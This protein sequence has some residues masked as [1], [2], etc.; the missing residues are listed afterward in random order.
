[1]QPGQAIANPYILTPLTNGVGFYGRDSVLQFVRN[2]LNSPY[3][4]VIVLFGQRRIG[5]TSLLH[6]LRQ[7]G[8][9]PA[10][11]RPIY[12]DLQGRAEHA[13]DQVLFGLAREICRTLSIELPPRAAFEDETFFQYGFLPE[14]YRVIGHDRLLVLVDEFDVL[15]GEHVP[16]DAAYHVLFSYLQDL[17][18]DEQRH[19]TFIFV[20]GRRL[21]ELPSRIKATFKSAQCKRISALDRASATDLIVEPAKGLV[22]FDKDAIERLHALTSGHPYF[23]QLLCYELVDRCLRRGN[24]RIGAHD[25]S[26]DVLE[27]AM[28]LGMGGL[29]WFWD[30]FPPAE[31]FLLATVAHLTQAHEVAS[32]RRIGQALH[33]HGVRLQGMELSTAPQVLTEWE[34]IEPVGR[35]AFRFRVDFLRQWI[36]AKHSLDEAKRELEQVSA[37]AVRDYEQARRLHHDGLLGEAIAA[38]HRALAAN[39]NHARAQLG[40]AQALYELGQLEHAIDAFEKAYRTDVESARDGLVAA[41]RDAGITLE[42]EGRFDQ[43]RPHYQRMLDITPDDALARQRMRNTWRATAGSHLAAGRWEQAVEAYREALRYVPDDAVIQQAVTELEQRH[44]EAEGLKRRRQQLE[45]AVLEARLREEQTRRERLEVDVAVTLKAFATFTI[46]LAVI[47]IVLAWRAPA[48]WQP[49][50]WPLLVILPAVIFGG[51]LWSRRHLLRDSAVPDDVPAR[52]GQRTDLG[53]G[54]AARVDGSGP[55][56][57]GPLSP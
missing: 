54:P 15:G 34:I 38:Y 45:R 31:R 47:S 19:L 3:Q 5:K 1:M 42:S 56:D 18:I 53:H 28:E 41:H 39:P 32:L 24:D 46:G 27:T 11:C 25:I 40:L 55:P 48:S 17:L 51:Y 52:E 21:D 23:L 57:A 49:Q 50:L 6:Q 16:P 26:D 43:A 30:E 35:D 7:P 33:E 12:F 14:V 29:A 4:N 10:G 8:E 9:T 2:T 36:L 37:R 13:L 22:R 20:V 44:L